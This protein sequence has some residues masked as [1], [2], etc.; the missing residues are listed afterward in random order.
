[1]SI[2]LDSAVIGVYGAFSAS[3]NE[4]TTDA[5]AMLDALAFK[6]KDA[7]LR[8]DNAIPMALIIILGYHVIR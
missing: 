2:D 3:V 8:P 7:E 6:R 1:M 4:P 5:L